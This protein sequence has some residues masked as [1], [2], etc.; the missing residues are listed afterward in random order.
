[1][2]LTA[3][4]PV[5]ARLGRPSVNSTNPS[6]LQKGEKIT[7]KRKAWGDAVNNNNIWILSGENQFYSS[8]GF[9]ITD[10]FKSLPIRPPLFDFLRISDLWQISKGE[11][12]N[13]GVIDDGVL[14]HRALNNKVV[15]LNNHSGT[16]I[17]NH[18]TT[19]ACIISAFD[20]SSGKVGI[21][22]MV[23]KIFS[24]QINI[25]KKSCNIE[26]HDLLNALNAMETAG[27]EIINMSF[28]CDRASFF[29][30]NSSGRLIQK[31][32]D[33]LSQKGV[34]LI[35]ATG[36]NRRHIDP[37]PDRFPAGYANVFSIT[38]YNFSGRIDFESN[39]WAGV[40]IAALKEYYFDDDQFE[41]SNGTSGAA[42][43]MTGFIA[44]VYKNL[45]FPKTQN[46]R[47]IF[48]QMP[49][50]TD[51]FGSFFPVP[52]FETI[53]FINQIK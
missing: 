17:N 18:G 36:N 37:K 8:E 10:E 38:G 19:M 28:T 4:K 32:I 6:Y 48:S 51:P 1:M 13:I 35:C 43:I 40:T 5:N 9:E 49:V 42:A 46:L 20:E 7:L 47:N 53:K 41:N 45:F 23:N 2:I 34:L 22:P 25:D 14:N 24:Y 16:N 3:I 12:I 21:A 11:G 27:V 33:A 52:K 31:K 26:A 50:V 15:Q 44:C 39:C 29:P 30:T